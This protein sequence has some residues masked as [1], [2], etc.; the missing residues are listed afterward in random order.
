MTAISR[1]SPRRRR[2]RS[3]THGS[4][5]TASP[6]AWPRGPKAMAE[7]VSIAICGRRRPGGALRPLRGLGPLDAFDEGDFATHSRASWRTGREP[8]PRRP[9]GGRSSAFSSASLRRAR[10][11]PYLEV[12]ELLVAEASARAGSAQCAARRRRGPLARARPT[13]CQASLADAPRPRPRLLRAR[14]LR[15]V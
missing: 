11:K 5:S 8:R 7:A 14:G 10:L 13:R 6:S 4:S 15:P 12:A 9:L 3:S 2:P 1:S